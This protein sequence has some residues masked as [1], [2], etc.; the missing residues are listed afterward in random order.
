M[1]AQCLE[2]IELDGEEHPI[3]QYPLWPIRYRLPRSNVMSTA[4]S[5]GYRGYWSVKDNRLWLTKLENAASKP[6]PEAWAKLFPNQP[7]P[8]LANW[9]SGTIKI[10][11]GALR[12][13]APSF[14]I[15]AHEFEEC[16]RFRK[17]QLVSRKSRRVSPLR[18]AW[19]WGCSF[20]GPV[21]ILGIILWLIFR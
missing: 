19:L 15:R 3:N 14:R 11:R 12:F 17:G 9:Y 7:Q 10:G 18:I 1:T 20:V 6:W 16:L 5:R 2:T 8:V 13:S 4:C 21:I